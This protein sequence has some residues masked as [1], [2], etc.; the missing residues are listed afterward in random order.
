VNDPVA[1]SLLPSRGAPNGAAE[2]DPSRPLALY[3]SHHGQRGFT[4][5]ET[6]VAMAVMAILASLAWP[7][8]ASAVQRSR[9]IEAT[10]A[11]MQVQLAQERWRSGHAAYAAD[12]AMLG[13]GARPLSY[14]RLAITGSTTSGYT[15]VA[16]AIGTQASDMPCTSLVV[17]L[18]AGRTVLGSTGSAAASACWG[19]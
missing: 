5:I 14:Y 10:A 19:S 7:S 3:G 17:T 11:L 16:T 12:L 6:L 18:D 8:F 13:L 15:V 9:R 4:L 1:A 2:P